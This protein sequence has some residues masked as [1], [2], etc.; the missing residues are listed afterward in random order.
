MTGIGTTSIGNDLALKFDV[1]KITSGGNFTD[2]QVGYPV[3]VFDTVVGNNK[4]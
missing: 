4:N 2:L 3:Y 1:E